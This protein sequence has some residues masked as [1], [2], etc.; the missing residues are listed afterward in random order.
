MDMNKLTLKPGDANIRKVNEKN[1]EKRVAQTVKNLPSMQE[2]RFVFFFLIYFILFF[3]F[4]LKH[5]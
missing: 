4:T 1:M 5:V 3:N 2:T